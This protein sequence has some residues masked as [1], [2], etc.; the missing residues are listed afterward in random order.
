MKQFATCSLGTQKSNQALLLRRAQ[1]GKDWLVKKGIASNRMKT[2][3]RGENEPM[4]SNDTEDGRADNR[5]MEFY[6]Q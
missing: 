2:V 1:A 6:V 3:G 5:R 4:T